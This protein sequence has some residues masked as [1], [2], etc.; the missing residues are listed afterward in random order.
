M[1]PAEMLQEVVQGSGKIFLAT[2]PYEMMQQSSVDIV[3]IIL[4]LI[5]AAVTMFLSIWYISNLHLA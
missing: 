1:L 2:W 5:I 4:L 3:T